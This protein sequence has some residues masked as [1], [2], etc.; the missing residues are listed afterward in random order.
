MMTDQL[1]MWCNVVMWM[2]LCGGWQQRTLAEPIAVPP[3]M[4]VMDEDLTASVPVEQVEQH[5]DNGSHGHG[6]NDAEEEEQQGGGEYKREQ[7][8]ASVPNCFKEKARPLVENHNDVDR[9]RSK[10]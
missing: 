5:Q 3:P 10:W 4:P 7:A 9:E 8:S 6:N 1:T 2:M